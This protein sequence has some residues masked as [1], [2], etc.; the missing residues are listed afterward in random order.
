MTKIFV[1]NFDSHTTIADIEEL[2][3][4][5]GDVAAARIRKGQKRPCAI[6]EMPYDTDAEEAIRAL[7]GTVWNGQCLEVRESTW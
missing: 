4:K 5:Y 3:L 1:S 7:D 2:F 6:V